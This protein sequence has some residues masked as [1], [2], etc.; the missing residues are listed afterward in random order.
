MAE[1]QKMVKML[2]IELYVNI[3]KNIIDVMVEQTGPRFQVFST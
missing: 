1:K 2:L 3:K